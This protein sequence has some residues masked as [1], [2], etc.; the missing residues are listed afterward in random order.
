MNP[1]TTPALPAHSAELLAQVRADLQSHPG[2]LILL[3]LWAP[4]CAPCMRLS[5]VIDE[6]A[7][8]L[9]DRLVVRKVDVGDAIN[10]AIELD[11]KSIPALLLYRDGREIGRLPQRTKQALVEAIEPLL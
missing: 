7:E 8:V 4:W 11:A 6:V 10:V 2:R 9:G 5:P 1:T 3:D